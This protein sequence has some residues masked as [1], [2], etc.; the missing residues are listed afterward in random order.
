M[1]KEGRKQGKEG[2]RN[3]DDE[4]DVWENRQD[5]RT[6]IAMRGANETRNAR[7]EALEH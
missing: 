7:E 4:V 5:G 3:G 1:E 2:K 6:I